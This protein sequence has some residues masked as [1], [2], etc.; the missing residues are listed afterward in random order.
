MSGPLGGLEAKLAAGQPVTVQFIG[1][2]TV[3]G[4]GD[5]ATQGGWAGRFGLYLGMEFD[6]TVTYRKYAEN[7]GYQ[8][9]TVTYT[10]SKPGGVNL[11][12]GGVGSR[13]IGHHFGYLDHG[14]YAVTDPDLVVISTGYNEYRNYGYTPASF[15][16]AVVAYI[17]KLRQDGYAPTSQIVVATQHPVSAVWIFG[18]TDEA[19][20]PYYNAVT[21][22][23]VGE[24]VPLPQPVMAS[25][26]HGGVWVADTRQSF[27]N[28]PQPSLVADGLHPNAAG[29][30]T[31]AEWT[32][33]HLLA[34]SSPVVPVAPF[35]PTTVA[36]AKV[37][38][39]GHLYSAG[40]N[41]KVGSQFRRVVARA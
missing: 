14:I 16:D 38:L 7:I 6:V 25:T 9:S 13:G 40:V 24:T 17:D 5:E 11:Y 37:R 41:V 12:N 18:I 1:D 32:L 29:Y 20:V 8:S 33:E 30:S 28:V 2:S 10:G 26:S 15:A 19:M 4:T 31:L 22:A 34:A 35:T 21:S 23:L 3:A 27:D 39:A 36:R